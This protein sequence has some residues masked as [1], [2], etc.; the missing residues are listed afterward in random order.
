MANAHITM[1]NE[2]SDT[3]LSGAI[4][5]TTHSRRSIMR[6]N[7]YPGR[8]TVESTTSASTRAY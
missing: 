8:S 1:C 6:K 3:V 4:I 5:G 2:R 7:Y